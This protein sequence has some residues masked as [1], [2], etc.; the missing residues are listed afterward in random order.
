MLFY[1][2]Y[3]HYVLTKRLISNEYLTLKYTV[4]KPIL[5]NSRHLM[6]KHLMKAMGFI[7]QFFSDDYSKIIT[8]SD[9]H[10]SNVV[11]LR[12]LM[13]MWAKKMDVKGSKTRQQLLDGW[14]IDEE[15]YSLPKEL[16]ML[17][18][19]NPDIIIKQISSNTS[20]PRVDLEQGYNKLRATLTS[21][22]F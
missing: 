8:K 3:A 6:M 11:T 20:S 13:L 21:D 7:Y 14:H 17:V 1:R 9:R 4:Q 16:T 5:Q 19:N 12:T 15:M 18:F 2:L 22:F 10:N